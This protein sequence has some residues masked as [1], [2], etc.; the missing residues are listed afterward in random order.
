MFCKKRHRNKIMRDRNVKTFYLGG[1]IIV[2]FLVLHF[3]GQKIMNMI[4]FHSRKHLYFFLKDT[5]L[6]H[7]YNKV[8]GK[9]LEQEI[10]ESFPNT[11]SS[12]YNLNILK[13]LLIAFLFLL[14][15][16]S[17]QAHRKMWNQTT[18]CRTIL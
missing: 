3:R 5:N 10:Q 8:G 12:L 9:F 14:M 18:F 13:Y 2:V 7:Y 4:C 17:L 15:R 6:S 1:G 16:H 11:Y